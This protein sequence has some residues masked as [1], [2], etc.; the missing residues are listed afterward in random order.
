[1]K[2]AA[3]SLCL[4]GMLVA[5]VASLHAS[6][7][8][9]T[10]TDAD[11]RRELSTYFRNIEQTAPTMLGG[12]ATSPAAMAAV[13]Q[14][15][16]DLSPE[17]VA[18]FK[19]MM[20]EAPDWKVAPEMI[21]KAFPP[22]LIGQVKRVGADVAGRVSRA[23]EMREDVQTLAA[24]LKLLP[25][26][27]LAELGLDRAAVNSLA[28]TVGEATPLQAAML[29]REASE[30]G[31]WD[32]RGAA[33]I[34]ALPPA[35][36]RGSAAL[37]LHGPITDADRKNLVTFRSEL[38]ALLERIDKLP[39]ETRKSL[40]IDDFRAQLRQLDT[41][42]PDV[43]FMVR[44]NVPAEMVATL[45]KNVAFLESVASLDEKEL[46]DLEQFRHDLGSAFG[47]LDRAAGSSDTPG[48]A[49][50]L[51][52][53]S[54]AHL[55]VLQKGLSQYGRWQVALPA[56][57]ETLASPELPLR[58][59]ALQGKTV[60]PETIASL[61]AFRRDML[62]EVE[63][64]A[65]TSGID[66]AL[67]TRARAGLPSVPLKRL[68]LMRMTLATMPKDASR[69]DRLAVIA[70]HEINFNCAVS[71]PDPVPNINLDFIC[72]PIE[73]A[74]E[75]IEHGIISTVNSIVA[76]VKST[77]ENTI[78]TISTALT[79]AVNTVTAT[80]NSLVASITSTVTTIS[81]FIQTIPA[82]AWKAISSALNLLLDINI[83][84]GVTLRDL[85]ASG[86]KH[87]LE[88][89]KTLVGLTNQWWT[90]VG[91]FT[92]PPIP[93]PPAGAHTPWGD[94][95]TGA[96][97]ANF[98]RYKLLIDN[99]VGLIPDTET[100]LKFKIPAQVLYL[101]YDFLGM[102]LEQAASDADSAEGTARH[103]LVVTNFKDLKAHILMS[104]GGLALTTT[105][106]STQL[107][108]LINNQSLALQNT[109]RGE[110]LAVQ[111]LLNSTNTTTQALVRSESTE[112]QS[113]I[114]AESAEM[115]SDL[116]SFEKFTVRL[117]IER[118][119]QAGEGKALAIFQILEPRGYLGMV[120]D[121]VRETIASMGASSYGVGQAQKY[122]DQGMRL[123]ST[124]SEKDAFRSFGEAYRA[125]TAQ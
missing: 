45:E 101:G 27:K 28:A 124:G 23:E 29:H 43:L 65:S 55:V 4:L 80:V 111:G 63:A 77:L 11:V 67:V 115:R 89:M 9:R 52:D 90:T 119:L 1:M 64:A 107:T 70:M 114:R 17:E 103:E 26:A 14:R 68:E 57:Y 76:S 25:D 98:A 99:L 56:F 35:L 39:P 105:S 33:A 8:P 91:S 16:A 118:T 108:N 41:A 123:M 38:V 12:V 18:A 34:E 50:M 60:E 96:A 47:K 3:R 20:A 61:E 24:V 15:I 97:A 22:E 83:K 102:C 74:L 13:Q 106:N 10:P 75:A 79:S 92:L 31:G 5:P 6:A 71:M 49:A 73:D 78:N 53:L 86:V 120:S 122:F 2:H 37:A 42:P 94:A 44:H 66:P 69:A 125:A 117:A 88:S 121:V 59:A 62:A 116:A 54:P 58:M 84:N 72:N 85:V 109:I 82:L 36:R 93:C 95:G 48:A 46:K 112:T 81:S 51:A 32:A 7:V 104:V 19:K 110:G 30:A 21:A 40:K 87:G 113:L 100:S